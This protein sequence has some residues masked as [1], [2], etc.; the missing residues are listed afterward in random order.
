MLCDSLAESISENSQRIKFHPNDA[1]VVEVSKQF[2]KDISGESLAALARANNFNFEAAIQ[3]VIT[4]S[5]SEERK[6]LEKC[7][8]AKKSFILPKL[9]QGSRIAFDEFGEQI[10]STLYAVMSDILSGIKIE[11]DY[12]GEFKL[13]SM[14]EYA[15]VNV[16]LAYTQRWLEG[17]SRGLDVL[18]EDGL[19][20][21]HWVSNKFNECGWS[22]YV[23]Q[24]SGDQGVDVVAI[25]DGVSLG[26]QCK[27][28]SG[29]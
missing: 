5:Y 22:S 1:K 16:A 8:D 6:H 25:K 9:I 14:P 29:Q 13:F 15:M 18:P 11:R 27:R 20:F 23:T 2:P 7:L 10:P 4:A 3:E 26:V 21:E 17:T 24:G 12:S 28:Y 19:E